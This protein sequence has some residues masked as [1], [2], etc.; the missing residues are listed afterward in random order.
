MAFP[1]LRSRSHRAAGLA[2]PQERLIVVRA[3][4]HPDVVAARAGVPV[5]L[6]FRR[7]ESDPCSDAVLL[8]ELGRF[9]ELPE[10]RSVSIDCGI[11]EPGEYEF[12]CERGNLR[13][14]VV[15]R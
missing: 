6:T 2:A 12:L 11:L 9:A 3:G 1:L 14:R 15:V 13:G 4:Y 7:E 5:R 8:P 10:G